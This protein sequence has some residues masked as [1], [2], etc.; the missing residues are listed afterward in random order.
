MCG[1]FTLRTPL[2]VLIEQFE[3]SETTPLLPR[4]NIAPTQPI[5]VVRQSGGKETRQLCLLRWGLIPAWAKEPS[6]GARLINAR[7]ETVGEKPAFRSAFKSRRCLIPADGYYEWKKIGGR[8]QP[9]HIR[10]EDERPFALA[11]LWER[12]EGGESGTPLET[13]TIITTAANAATAPIH[14]RM[15]AIL[16]EEEYSLW[17]D[18]GV[19][20]RQM[21]ARLLRPFDSQ[22][23]GSVPVSTH[24]NNA[25][26]DDPRCVAT[27]PDLFH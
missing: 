24:V 21:L 27:Q 19:Q 22:P 4:F 2:N 10:L 25:R 14:D 12:W 3:L 1:R 7:A 18:P 5:A 9:Y 6:I 15:P 13:C 17:L 8:K 23:M 20:D 11:G 26:N 16:P